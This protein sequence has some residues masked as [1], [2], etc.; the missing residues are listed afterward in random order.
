MSPELFNISFLFLLIEFFFV[1]IDFESDFIRVSIDGINI[2][3]EFLLF[4]SQSN[5]FKE[6]CDF[7]DIPIIDLSLFYIF[8]PI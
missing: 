4:F 3:T 1:S 6:L 5:Y 7:M 8:L 2:Q